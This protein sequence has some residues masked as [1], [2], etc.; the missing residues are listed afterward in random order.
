MKIRN[1]IVNLMLVFTGIAFFNFNL[2]TNIQERSYDS[3]Y[4]KMDALISQVKEGKIKVT[5]ER[6]LRALEGKK[7]A[8]QSTDTIINGY[9]YI[10]RIIIGIN[11][12]C[13]AFLCVYNCWPT[14]NKKL[15]IS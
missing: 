5:Q 8:F 7:L 1:K 15:E 12:A 11:L 6:Y 3:D 13:I 9:E 14:R 2:Y 10:F 4:S